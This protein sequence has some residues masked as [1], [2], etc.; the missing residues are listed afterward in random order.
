VEIVTAPGAIPNPSW[1]NFVVTAKARAAIRQYL[2]GL[3]RSEAIEL[4][5]RLINQSLAEFNLSLPDISAMTLAATAGEL[6]M[7]DA[8]ELFEAVRKSR[9]G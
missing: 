8:D 9:F 1:V 2:K 7:A 3:R 4:G 6:G 5:Q